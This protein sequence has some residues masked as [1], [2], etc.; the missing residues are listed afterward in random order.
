MSAGGLGGGGGGG[1]GEGGSGLGPGGSG[2]GGSG[3]GGVGLGGSGLGGDGLGGSGLGGSGLG[4]SGLGGSGL[5]G[6]GL[7]G[8]G[9]GGSGLG[10]TG[11]A[12]GSGEDVS[13]HRPSPPG[14]AHDIVMGEPEAVSITSVEPHCRPPSKAMYPALLA[15]AEAAYAASF[16]V[17]NCACEQAFESWQS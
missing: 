9:L 3:L 16:A 14:E 7:G 13:Q 5:G 17:L 10:G 15:N 6:S 1:E 12:S 2:L 11:D 4:G 8:S